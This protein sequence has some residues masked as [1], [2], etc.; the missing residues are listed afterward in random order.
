MNP[1]NASYRGFIDSNGEV[2]ISYKGGT[3]LLDDAA[4]SHLK[5]FKIMQPDPEHPRVL[6]IVVV[7]RKPRAMPRAPLALV[8]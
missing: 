7:E 2:Q 8:R 6:T 3:Y 5:L 1:V 4:V